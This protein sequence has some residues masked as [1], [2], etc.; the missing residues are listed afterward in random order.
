MRVVAV[1]GL[2]QMFCKA[3]FRFVASAAILMDDG[4][5]VLPEIAGNLGARAR[6]RHGRSAFGAAR[7]GFVVRG[8]FEQHR[9][10][11]GARRAINIGRQP[12]P[13]ARPNHHI[14]LDGAF[15]DRSSRHARSPPVDAM[16]GLRL[17][18]AR[19]FAITLATNPAA[20]E[21]A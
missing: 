9:E 8:A 13:V 16:P 4:I 1:F 11:P 21:G 10:R 3:A 14:A 18:V 20:G 12:D 7:R 15:G 17:P 2:A 19:V 6:R 5:T